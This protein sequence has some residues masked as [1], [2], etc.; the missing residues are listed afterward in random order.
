[1]SQMGG[2]GSKTPLL[3]C[4]FIAMTLATIG[5]PGF[6]NFW[7][8]FGIFLSLGQDRE[9]LFFLVLAASGIIIS[10]IF[11]LRAVAKIFYGTASDDLLEHEKQNPILDLKYSEILPASI[12]LIPL[13][14]L[15]LWP[16]ATSE[17]ID[18]EINIRYSESDSSGVASLPPCCPANKTEPYTDSN[19][20]VTDSLEN[21]NSNK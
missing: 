2:L 4:F 14:F 21:I 10:A 17:R 18:N 19:Q 20:S 7:G 5:L 13:L 15:G 8:E 11:G 16:K 6:G 1:M 12:I 3:A 9:N